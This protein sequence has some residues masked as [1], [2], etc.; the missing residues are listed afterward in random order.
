[1]TLDQRL[2]LGQIDAEGPVVGDETFD[3]LDV[4]TKLPQGLVRL[5]RRGLEF[6][7]PGAAD[8]RES[9]FDHE[10]SHRDLDTVVLIKFSMSSDFAIATSDLAAAVAPVLNHCSDDMPWV[11]LIDHESWPIEV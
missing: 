10:L 8:S 3:P 1:M 4:G 5:A 11:V 2:I 9:S 7:S 6:F